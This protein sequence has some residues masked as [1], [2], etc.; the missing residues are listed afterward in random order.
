MKMG[1]FDSV[2]CFTGF[3]DWTDWSYSETNQ[4]GQTRKCNRNCGASENRTSHDWP[5]FK[6]IASDSCEQ[7]KCC[8][9]CGS[10]EK[11]TAPHQWSEWDYLSED[12][13]D[14]ERRCT[15][16]QQPEDRQLHAWDVWQHESP[17]SCIQVRFCRRCSSG[18]EEKRPEDKDH[19]WTEP[20][21]D[22][23][24]RS[25]QICIRCDQ[26]KSKHEFD[27]HVFGS[28]EEDRQG[29]YR[30]RCMECGKEES[31]IIRPAN[32][33]N[34]PSNSNDTLRRHDDHFR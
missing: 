32:F 6:Y 10:E 22:D 15:R 7:S 29:H 27:L 25:E 1:F 17:K 2:K 30:R 20:I 16:C 31:T 14:Q 8:S 19:S 24:K 18:K 28:W 26:R 11:K 23:C 21:R 9:R 13:C 34:N 12:R 5:E 3:H 33:P 4:C